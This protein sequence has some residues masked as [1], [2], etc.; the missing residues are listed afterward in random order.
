MTTTPIPEL[1]GTTL[2][3]IQVTQD[4]ITFTLSSGARLYMFHER[5]CCEAVWIEDINGDITDLLHTPILLAEERTERKV[6]SYTVGQEPYSYESPIF[7]QWTF[8][9]F[10]TI[11]GSVDIRWCGETEGPYS[12]AVEYKLE[13]PPHV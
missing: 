5:D 8:Y 7:Q 12:L 6:T 4:Q 10:R 13:E 2:T 11:K 9:T 1:F 3:Q